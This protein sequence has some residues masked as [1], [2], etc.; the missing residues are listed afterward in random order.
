MLLLLLGT[1]K[2]LR[3][4]VNVENQEV[5]VLLDTGA[6]VSVLPKFLIKR[7]IGDGSR[8]VRLGRSKSV[9]PFANPDVQLE[10]P[11]CLS[12]EI[13]GFRLTHPFY[14]MDA[15]I[16]AVVGIDLLNAAK[17]VIDVMN[18]CAYSHHFARLEVEPATQRHEPVFR[19]DNATYFDPLLSPSSTVPSPAQS[20]TPSSAQDLGGPPSLSGVGAS[21]S[22]LHSADAPVRSS[23]PAPVPITSP[24]TTVDYLRQ[25][26]T[27]ETCCLVDG[28]T[29][30]LHPSPHALS[31]SAL[32]FHPHTPSS[33]PSFQPFPPLISVSCATSSP[34]RLPAASPLPPQPSCHPTPAVFAQ[35]S[36]HPDPPPDFSHP[37]PEPP[38]PPDPPPNGMISLPRS[39]G[40]PS[41][42]TFEHGDANVAE[43]K[44]AT[45]VLPEHVNLLFLQTVENS[46]LSSEVCK[47]LK[48]LLVE[49]TSTFAKDFADLGFC[50]ILQH[51][52]DTGDVRPVNHHVA[53]P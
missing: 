4:P 8:H 24:L 7:L 27:P 49:H 22:L 30:S 23:L 53:L 36:P 28:S 52:I 31:P 29:P 19:V 15:D 9:R 10:G 33:S 6:E 42:T 48:D 13:C 44:S 17:L 3:V 20:G 12:V 50:S 38:D 35:P 26:V 43:L 46:S 51:D 25:D 37:L 45:V 1:V 5:T 11:W 2:S 40:S 39:C 32:P 34:D 14:R 21:L 41:P 16:P 47:G 18:R